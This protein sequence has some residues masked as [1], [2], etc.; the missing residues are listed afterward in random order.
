MCPGVAVALLCWWSPAI[1]VS[2]AL[3]LLVVRT[4]ASGVALVPG[5]VAFEL[6]KKAWRTGRGMV[7]L[8]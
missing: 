1:W 8:E 6:E 4:F 5:V 2:Q 7:H 3:R